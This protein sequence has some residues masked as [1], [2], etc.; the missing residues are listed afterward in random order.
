LN[1]NKEE[2]RNFGGKKTD[3]FYTG[4]I[5]KKYKNWL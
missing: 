3:I 4:E 2:T 1:L 5:E